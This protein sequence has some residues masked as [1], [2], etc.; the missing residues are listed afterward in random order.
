[1]S[2]PSTTFRSALRSGR[3]LLGTLVTSDAGAVAETLAIAGWDWLF[4]DCEHA[5]LNV[6][7]AQRLLQ[8]IGGRT[9]AVIRIPDQSETSIKQ[10]LDTGCSG[11][12]VPQVNTAEQA[13]NVARFA[14][15]PPIGGRSVGIA[16]A[17]GY[18]SQFAEYTS[19]ANDDVAVIV[20]AEHADAVSNIDSILATEGIDAVFVGPYD[21]SGSLGLVGQVTHPAVRAAVSAISRACRAH[22]AP[23]GLF[24]LTP[25]SIHDSV[26]NGATLLAVGSDLSMLLS[27]S[28]A[29]R[30]QMSS[31]NVR[32]RFRRFRPGDA[33]AV[34]RL[35]REA[36]ESTDAF[37]TVDG[38]YDDLEAIDHHY[39][40]DGGEFLVGELDGEIVA[41]G[42]VAI[43]PGGVAEVR[44]MRVAPVLQ[45]NGIGRRLL[46]LLEK[47]AADAGC[48]TVELDTT[49]NQRAAQK[50]FDSSGYEE[51]RRGDKGGGLETIFYV[52]S[53]AAA[54]LE[55][56]PPLAP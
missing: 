25:D 1:M 16:R 38:Y 3:V 48:A 20:Q 50:L 28:R 8:A 31:A 52:K 10:A 5:A 14:R 46:R 13:R 2:P 9:H 35:H 47:A 22:D 42:G 36:L 49:V 40:R 41:I 56:A 55:P 33:D 21:L 12:I 51:V 32:P 15:Y 7:D 4:I 26:V 19:H 43:H 11:V 54:S 37:I 44:R 29:A 17:Q 34:M 39:L 24:G 23:W 6:A 27:A 53:L 18:G 30:D 45:G